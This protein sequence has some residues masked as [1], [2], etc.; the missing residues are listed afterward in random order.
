MLSY[1]QNRKEDYK[2]Y[3]GGLPPRLIAS[4]QWR[5]RS[6]VSDGFAVRIPLLLWAGAPPARRRGKASSACATKSIPHSRI[7]IN[8][9][10]FFAEREGFGRLVASR[11][12]Y[13]RSAIVCCCNS[14]PLP[15]NCLWKYLFS[16][17]QPKPT[18]FDCNSLT[19]VTSQL[20]PP[21][22]WLYFCNT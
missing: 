14:L 10:L 1:Q 15:D 5:L 8:S 19:S 17:Y 4:R 16:H 21:F 12:T 20:L 22:E 18:I 7:S 9:S 11:V 2:L 6:L 13:L 3:V